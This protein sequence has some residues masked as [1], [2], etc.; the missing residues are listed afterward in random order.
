MSSTDTLPQ[1]QN[2][3]EATSFFDNHSLELK[4][5]VK[6][7]SIGRNLKP[8]EEFPY[9][10]IAHVIKD[11]YFNKIKITGDLTLRITPMPDSDKLT[12]QFVKAILKK[13]RHQDPLAIMAAMHQS[14]IDHPEEMKRFHK[15]PLV[16]PIKPS[17]T[18]SY[19]PCLRLNPQTK[20]Y[21]WDICHTKLVANSVYLVHLVQEVKS[22]NN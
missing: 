18:Y 20:E 15:K 1:R 14:L 2:A 6:E 17:N 22:P 12:A 13:Y 4:T 7:F 3:K 16:I 19:Y 11:D 21:Y 9:E 8:R 5:H 10:Y